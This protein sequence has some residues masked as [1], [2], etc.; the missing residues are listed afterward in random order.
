MDKP[1]SGTSSDT[2]VAGVKGEFEKPGILM[3]TK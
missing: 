3:G 2:K 1:L